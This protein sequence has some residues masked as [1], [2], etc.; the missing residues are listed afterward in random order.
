MTSSISTNP[1]TY[2]PIRIPSPISI[3]TPGSRVHRFATSEM[4]GLRTAMPV[5]RTSVRSASVSMA[6]QCKRVQDPQAG[7]T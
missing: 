4:N 6:A 2:G 3:T 7:G 1:R 5:I